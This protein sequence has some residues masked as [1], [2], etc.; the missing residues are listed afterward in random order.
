MNFEQLSNE[1]LANLVAT[2]V[3]VTGD[4]V[5]VNEVLQT[6][7]AKVGYLF[8]DQVSEKFIIIYK[9]N[10]NM[11]WKF[12][13]QADN[14]LLYD[15]STADWNYPSFSKRIV[16]PIK[17][18]LDYPQFEIWFRLN[19]LPVVNKNDTLYCYCNE[20]LPEHQALA[21]SLQGQITIENRP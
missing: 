18:S 7:T 21:D 8:N 10:N 1:Y 20:I 17:L 14:V 3:F 4:L 12:Y 6:S 15:Y 11:T 2:G 13:N 19:N 9:V 16:A 5:G